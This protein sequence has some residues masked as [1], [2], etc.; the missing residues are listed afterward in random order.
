MADPIEGVSIQTKKVQGELV[1][2][3]VTVQPGATIPQHSHSRGYMVYPMTDGEGVKTF[4]KDGRVVR[5]EPMKVTPGEPYHVP[6]TGPGEKI[7]IKN[8][9]RGV[10]TFGKLVDPD[11][12]TFENF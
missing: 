3:K 9:G 7:A 12:S 2:T 8:T 4:Y 5:E 11:P 10:V 6:A 1:L